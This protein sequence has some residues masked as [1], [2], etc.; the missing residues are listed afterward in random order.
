MVNSPADKENFTLLLAAIR[1]KLDVQSLKDGKKY[2]RT[3][4]GAANAHYLKKIEPQAVAELVDHIFIMAYDMH[5][6]WDAY[7]D[8]G[9]PLYQPAGYSPQYKNSVA[10]GVQAYRCV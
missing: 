3:V 5:G 9:A 2:D 10:D 7:S 4:A 1:Q 6:S 8:F